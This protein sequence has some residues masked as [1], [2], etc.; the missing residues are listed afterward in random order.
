MILDYLKISTNHQAILQ[1]K[2][3]TW[4]FYH[5]ALLPGAEATGARSPSSR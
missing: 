5:D 3:K 1:D 4:F 2:G